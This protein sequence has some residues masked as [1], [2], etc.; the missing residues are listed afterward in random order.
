[1]SDERNVWMAFLVAA[2]IVGATWGVLLIGSENEEELPALPGAEPIYLTYSVEGIWEGIE[3]N[4][5]FDERITLMESGGL[6]YSGEGLNV[7]GNIG[8]LAYYSFFILGFG[9]YLGDSVLETAWGEKVVET[10]LQY[11]IVLPEIMQ[12]ICI[13]QRGA[14]TGLAYS[15]HALAPNLDVTYELVNMSVPWMEDL[16]LKQDGKV[17]NYPL[18]RNIVL[19]FVNGET[20]N[21]THDGG[22]AWLIG[23]EA[24]ENIRFSFT[25]S[26]C[27]FLI[28]DEEDIRNMVVG[29]GFQYDA[30]R[31]VIGN[32]SVDFVIEDQVVYC[33]VLIPLED[34]TSNAHLTVSPIDE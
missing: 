11:A 25:G 9:G 1:M 30:D 12:S 3:V 6:G 10:H 28:C 31:S 13:C 7:T 34:E 17:L 14:H 26:N 23:P 32:G 29:G 8:K 4:G 21:F 33:M 16:D 15:V 27:T 24:D 5:S 2:A 19:D 20:I 18:T 22:P